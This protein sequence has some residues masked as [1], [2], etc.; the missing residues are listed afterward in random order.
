MQLLWEVMTWGGVTWEPPAVMLHF[1]LGPQNGKEQNRDPD[2]L[3]W[4]WFVLLVLH[5]G[6]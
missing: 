2:A 1:Y 6:Q 3:L 4:I 5:V